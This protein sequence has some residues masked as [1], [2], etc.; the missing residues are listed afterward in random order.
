MI[1]K[2]NTIKRVKNEKLEEELQHQLV[3]RIY[4]DYKNRKLDIC[5][6]HKN[7]ERFFGSMS[8]SFMYDSD[9]IY[10]CNTIPNDEDL[11]IV[12]DKL[13]VKSEEDMCV[14]INKLIFLS[15]PLIHHKHH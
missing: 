4:N 1:D 3:N 8:Y 5:I 9:S 12:F 13:K 10:G 2:F 14:A 15:V 7:M 6:I 11:T